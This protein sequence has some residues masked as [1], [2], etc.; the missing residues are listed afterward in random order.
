M[1]DQVN[2]DIGA[3][4]SSAQASMKDLEDKSK[5]SFD[6]MAQ[7]AEKSGEEVSKAY[8]RA[9]IRTEK[10]IKE[11]SA[12]ARADFERIKKSGVASANDI[13]RAHT[14]MTAK[15][16]K[17]NREMGSLNQKLADS[18]KNI[19]GRLVQ[20]GVV[21]AGVFGFKVIKEAT[22][23]EAALLDLQKVLSDTDPAAETFTKQTEEMAKKFGVSSTEVLQ[24]A[25]NFKQAG[26]DVKESFELQEQALKLVI[27]GD[28]EAAMASEL[29]VSTLKG[30]KAPASDA[31]RLTDVL[32]EVS[33][34]YATNLQ[35]LAIGMAEISPIAAKM[36]FSFEETAG[37]LT[38]IIE[39]FRSGS[40]SSQALRTGLLKL[41]DD[42]VPVKNALA[43][44]G[45]TQRDLVTK[46]LR[47]GKDILLDVAAAFRGLNTD[48]KLFYASQL[49]GIRQSAKVVEVFDQL[50][51]VTEITNVAQKA[52]GSI[53]RE[54]AIR[55]ASTEIKAKKAGQSFN[56]MAKTIGTLLL[57]AWN[58]F[59]DLSIIA[60]DLITKGV[61]KV[62]AAL[63]AIPDYFRFI[64]PVIWLLK[65]VNSEVKESIKKHDEIKK[66][67]EEVAEAVEAVTAAFEER[68]AKREEDEQAAVQ[69]ADAEVK[70]L[71][72]AKDAQLAHNEVLRQ[73]IR[74]TK[75]ELKDLESELKRAQDFTLQVLELIRESQVRREQV[76]LAPVEK[77]L[78]DLTRAEE[79]F[80]Q[81]GEARAEGNIDE[82][83]Q[84]TLDAVNAANAV[85]EVQKAAAEESGVSTRELNKAAF[86]AE[87]LV[88]A[89]LDFSSGMEGAVEEAIPG[90]KKGLEDMATELKLGE[91][92]LDGVK[93]AIKEALSTAEELKSKLSEDTEA[94]HTQFINTVEVGGVGEVPG[95]KKGVHLPGYGGGDKILAKLERGEDVIRKESVKSL[96]R[97]GTGAMNAIHN[98]DIKG[99][100]NSLPLPGFKE[101]RQTP[102]ST[103]SSVNVNLELA[104][105][106]FPMT[107]EESTA[108]EFVKTIKSVNIVRGRKKTVY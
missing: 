76:G 15:I 102:Q 18:F 68:K 73:N 13:K 49:T 106:S 42:S 69:A 11:S 34:K 47:S 71:E 10:A 19:K 5:K 78:D 44:L 40:E 85:L 82:A 52:N 56:I 55:L 108:E 89:A 95:F 36:G 58:K 4:T 21:A 105:D 41:L 31:A 30:F 54:V 83:R 62:Q 51:K 98:G 39:V 29:L 27:A 45:V 77:L 86:E 104:G 3:N 8:K 7:D 59:L 37:L 103:S 25:A 107:A 70:A 81:A 22:E 91:A 63:D 16:K 101:G 100:V 14:A 46:E 99:L 53:N 33:N 32:N 12:K 9:G 57:P 75:Q 20:L 92:T 23:F 38:P 90:V 6:R 35:E 28:L 48:Q 72:V 87:K 1:A 66:Q 96:Q 2:I 80:R 61:L 67:E 93:N 79:R 26:F 88:Q 65:K 50:G 84:L 74:D 43:D 97:L 64:N 17:N 24:G 60:L 94:T